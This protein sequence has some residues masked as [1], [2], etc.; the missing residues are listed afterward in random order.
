MLTGRIWP[1]FGSIWEPKFAEVEAIFRPDIAKT[2]PTELKK[3]SKILVDKL[4]RRWYD[5]GR[6]DDVPFIRYWVASL[7]DPLVADIGVNKAIRGDIT[8]A[9]LANEP[10]I[11]GLRL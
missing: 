11:Y 4:F 1:K 5:L 9:Y 6:F 7:I 3:K 8:Y 2:V 10:Y